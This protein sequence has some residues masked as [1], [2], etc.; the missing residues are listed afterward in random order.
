MWIQC[1]R[2]DPILEAVAVPE[3]SAITVKARKREFR[4]MCHD[5][6]KIHKDSINY[7]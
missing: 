4:R 6:I 5:M 7:P 2:N 3:D 1:F